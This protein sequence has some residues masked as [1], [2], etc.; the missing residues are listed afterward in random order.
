MPASSAPLFDDRL[1]AASNLLERRKPTP[2]GLA[3]LLA[4]LALFAA[5]S[6][7]ASLVMPAKKAAITPAAA[8]VSADFQ[9]SGSAFPDADP[10]KPVTPG[11]E[12]I[13]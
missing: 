7:L 2:S 12:P 9:L 3:I 1:H 11:S 13:R 6:M 5:A 10:A 4:V 8:P